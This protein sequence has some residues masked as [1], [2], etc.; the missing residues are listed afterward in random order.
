MHARTAQ[1][2]ARSIDATPAL[3]PLVPELLAGLDA[4]GSEPVQVAEFLRDKLERGNRVLDLGMGKGAVAV[5]LARELDVRVDGIDA[6]PAFVEEARAKAEEA[7][8]LERCTFECGDLRSALGREEAYDAVLWVGIGMVFGTFAETVARL[9]GVVKRGGLIYIDDV[10]R[11]EAKSEL[12]LFG[13]ELVLEHFPTAA[14][15][16]ELNATI[17]ELLHDNASR[18]TERYPD[19]CEAVENWIRVQSEASKVL[20]ETLRPA[21]YLVRRVR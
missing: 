14:Q 21:V 12:T 7:G 11:P 16:A 20:E 3:L 17:L 15:T 1:E 10:E 9:R 5:E 19:Q 2:V 18:V 8:V 4:L 13:D 6:M